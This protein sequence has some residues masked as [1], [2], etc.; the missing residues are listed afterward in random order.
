MG[1]TT[2]AARA[3]ESNPELSAEQITQGYQAI[4]NNDPRWA[5][6]VEQMRGKP[7]ATYVLTEVAK[8]IVEQAGGQWHND[9]HVTD[10]DDAFGQVQRDSWI[11]R[12]GLEITVAAALGA[13]GIGL[14]AGAGGGAAAG[15]TSAANGLITPTASFG[16]GQA[17]S[18][19][20]LTATTG[21]DAAALASLPSAA[22]TTGGSTIASLLGGAKTAGDVIGGIG[23]AIGGATQG[24]ADNRGAT[25]DFELDRARLGVESQNAFDTQNTNRSRLEMDQR[26]ENAR[27]VYRAGWYENR[28]P[29]P[30]NPRGLTPL[31]ANYASSLDSLEEQA[32]SRLAKGPQFAT[33]QMPAPI[34]APLPTQQPKGK[35]EKVGDWLSPILTG[36]G[37]IF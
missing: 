35:G 22:A 12:N 10:S 21:L 32:M 25:D 3:P 36:I 7:N 18:T 29:G 30:F 8:K 27:D 15:G 6:T 5:A 28:Q 13:T 4:L 33:N 31:G 19:A 1:Q 2:Q 37:E 14:L 20:G 16:T 26:K 24:A 23:K 34:Q 11:R 17:I 9:W